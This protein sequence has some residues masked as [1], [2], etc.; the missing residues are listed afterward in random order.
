MIRATMPALCHVAK[1][2]GTAGRPRPNIDATTED[3]IWH[4]R[5][6]ARIAIR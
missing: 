5:Y 6:R 2:F 3:Y 1:R 4:E